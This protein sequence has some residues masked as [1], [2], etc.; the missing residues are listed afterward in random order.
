MKLST[1]L[2]IKAVV[3]I[4][5]GLGFVAIP[6]TVSSIYEITLD[7]NGLM[8]ARLYGSVFFG[9][10]LIVLLCRNA[11][12]NALKDITLSLAIADSIGFI[13]ALSAQLSG[14]LNSLG[15]INAALWLIFALG[16]WY[17]RFLRPNK[18]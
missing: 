1:F 6:A 2:V 18:A 9:V 15:W 10:G 14:I 8:M 16:L 5:F 11:N 13:V 4:V 3:C 7:P 17:Y 12:W